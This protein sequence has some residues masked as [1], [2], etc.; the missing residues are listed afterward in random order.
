MQFAFQ[1]APFAPLTTLRDLDYALLR[2]STMFFDAPPRLAGIVNSRFDFKEAMVDLVETSSVE[3]TGEDKWSM[4]KV[5]HEWLYD[6]LRKTTDQEFLQWSVNC[7]G[8]KA[9]KRGTSE[10]WNSSAPLYGHASRCMKDVA[11][12]QRIEAS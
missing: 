11:D 5:L 1:N 9:K 12:L 3:S 8:S 2:N 6:S 7:V 10:Y 4:H